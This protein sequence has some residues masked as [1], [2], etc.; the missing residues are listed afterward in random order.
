[1]TATDYR[2]ARR[3]LGLTQSELALVLDVGR[4]T[5]IR[6]ESGGVITAEAALAISLLEMRHLER[7]RDSIGKKDCLSIGK[8][9]SECKDSF[10]LRG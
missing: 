3:T 4:K 6:R 10:N 9:T 1:M 7:L 2:N 5:I 8:Q